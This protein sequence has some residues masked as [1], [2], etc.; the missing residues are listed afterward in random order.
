MAR[1]VVTLPG[2]G[3]GPEIMAPTVGVLAGLGDF[4]FE[5][6]PFGGAAIDASGTA[7]TDQ[8]LAA[9]RAADAV[10]LGAVGGPRWDTTDPAAPRPEQGLL[11][12]RKGLALCA[13]L[14]PVRPLPAL[15]GGRP[16]RRRR[17]EA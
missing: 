16:M 15:Y 4:E 9:C 11:G 1:R 5:E 6:H 12:L 7:L 10:L 13:N 2:D 14:R 8:T 17:I 3:I